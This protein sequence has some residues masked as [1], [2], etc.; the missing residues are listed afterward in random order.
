M[1]KDQSNIIHNDHT[2]G[3]IEDNSMILIIITV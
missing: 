1:I 3:L 2:K